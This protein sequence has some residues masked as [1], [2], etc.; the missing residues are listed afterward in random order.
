MENQGAQLR[1]PLKVMHTVFP[2][3]QTKPAGSDKWRSYQGMKAK[4]KVTQV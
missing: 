2:G 4:V 1:L 3:L